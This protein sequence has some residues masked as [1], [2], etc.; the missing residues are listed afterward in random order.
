V[1]GLEF[2]VHGLWLEVLGVGVWGLRVWVH[3]SWFRVKGLRFWIL[4]LGFGV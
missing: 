3:G 4:G 2:R 1:C